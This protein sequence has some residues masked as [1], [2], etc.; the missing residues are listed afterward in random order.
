[1]KRM[2][3]CLLISFVGICLYVPSACAV[4]TVDVIAFE[5]DVKVYARGS[6]TGEPCREDMGI[7]EGSK[8]VTG[9]GSY[10]DIAFNRESSNIVKI[11]ENSQVIVNIVGDDK[12]ELINGEVFASLE[13]LKKGETFRVKTPCATCGA[14][15]TAWGTK[16]DGKFTDV[17]VVDGNISLRG[18]KK[19]GT[20][21]EKAYTVKKG[22]ECRVK[23]FDVPGKRERISEDRLSGLKKEALELAVTAPR[24]P[25]FITR[26]KP[27]AAIID[28]RVD[29]TVQTKDPLRDGAIDRTMESR[30]IEKR[31]M[32]QDRDPRIV[33]KREM[34][35]DRMD[36]NVKRQ[37]RVERRVDIIAD[38]RETREE[39]TLD[40]NEIDR[41]RKLLPPK[42]EGSI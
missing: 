21:M 31:T 20:P 18:L 13:G 37:E 25:A 16:T 34:I 42:E 22:F 14:R 26:K 23:K 8:V 9:K 10:L 19:D 4:D 36:R 38:V 32:L 17:F 27:I 1:M 2:A 29:S 6:E 11:K 12:V 15:G 7:E 3:M 5:G 41:L 35:S 28:G 30:T 40:R 39:G 33:E 24:R